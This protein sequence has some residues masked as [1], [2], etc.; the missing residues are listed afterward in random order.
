[1]YEIAR[2]IQEV[3]GI[4]EIQIVFRVYHYIIFYA[5]YRLYIKYKSGGMGIWR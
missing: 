1:M 2:L 4:L 5:I 3:V